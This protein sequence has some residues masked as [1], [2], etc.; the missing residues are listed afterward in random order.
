MKAEK[1][2][3]EEIKTELN[4]RQKAFDGMRYQFTQDLSTAQQQ[5]RFELNIQNEAPVMR[6]EEEVQM[7]TR[8]QKP[9]FNAKLFMLDLEDRIN[10]CSGGT[11]DV[12]HLNFLA[13]EQDYLL[14]QRKMQDMRQ[15]NLINSLYANSSRGT[16]M[17]KFRIK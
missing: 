10:S 3:L 6:I 8:L 4:A 2:R 16:F 7:P 11:G 14:R 5:A 13:K 17:S 15:S 12:G 1:L 9:M